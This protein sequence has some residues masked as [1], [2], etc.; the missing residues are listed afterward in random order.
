[1]TGSIFRSLARF[2]Q[3]ARFP[4]RV[5]SG[6]A[7]ASRLRRLRSWVVGRARDPLSPNVLEQVS[8]AAFLGWIGFGA[9]ALS[10]SIY[11]PD[12]AFR[13]LGNQSCVAVLLV[14]ATVLTVFIKARTYS[15][16]IEHFP[17]GGGG[18]VA[19]LSSRDPNSG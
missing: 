15:A 2:R 9:N 19:R 13:T 8:L 16:V 3:A 6:D 5:H 11:G 4:Y 10:S 14:I 1:M 7:T 18:Y 12:E 17:F